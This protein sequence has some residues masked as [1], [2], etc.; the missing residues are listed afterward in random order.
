MTFHQGTFIGL[1]EKN[2]ENLA[3]DAK[4]ECDKYFEAR[5]TE[6]AQEKR[7]ETQEELSYETMF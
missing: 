4:L 1:C 5:A 2:Y 6:Q 3:L 7:R